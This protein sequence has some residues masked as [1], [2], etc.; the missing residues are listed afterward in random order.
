MKLNSPNV[1]NG[2]IRY[3]EVHFQPDVDDIMKMVLSFMIAQDKTT[4]EFHFASVNENGTLLIDLSGDP[5]TVFGENVVTV[6][7]TVTTLISTNSSRKN[8][9]VQNIGSLPIAI[10]GTTSVTYGAGYQLQPNETLYLEN[11]TGALYGISP[12]GDN[13]ICVV[14]L[15]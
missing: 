14:G 15:S 12:S 8:L 9:M 13:D 10:G 5:A 6:S 7:G 4:G 2:S 3:D 1:F 11:F